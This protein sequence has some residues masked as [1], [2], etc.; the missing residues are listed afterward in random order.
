[1]QGGGLIDQTIAAGQAA[2]K[3]LNGC[4]A[5]PDSDIVP[6]G[7]LAIYAALGDVVLVYGD[8]SMCAVPTVEL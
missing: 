1:M 2:F 7:S 3:Q 6:P 4:I 5:C 8:Y